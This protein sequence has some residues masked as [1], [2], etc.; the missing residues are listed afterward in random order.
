MGVTPGLFHH[1]MLHKSLAF[2]LKATGEGDG[3]ATF[4][5]YAAY[6]GNVD[7]SGDVLVK[8]AFADTLASFLEDGVLL[9]QHKRTDLIGR[10]LEAREDDKGLF[11]KGELCLAVAKARECYELMKAGILKKMSIGY[12]VTDYER[13][14]EHN[15]ETFAPGATPG[16]VARAMEWWGMA[17]K[18]VTLYEVSPVSI[19]ANPLADITA[20]KNVEGL[21]FDEHLLSTL[22]VV[23]GLKQRAAQ[24]ASIRQKD[25]RELS[26]K[27]REHLGELKSAIDAASGDI[28]A[29][30]TT[31]AEQKDDITPAIDGHELKE[32]LATR[33]A[34]LIAKGVL[35]AA[36]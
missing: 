16:D 6:F 3:V 19:P 2:H 27:H 14:G 1:S 21:R 26:E 24:I 10:P 28:A 8:G 29:L 17:L 30:L 7:R 13:L 5:G 12:D 9:A 35:S 34:A 36:V 11:L 32:R 18:R 22:A 23:K 31:N 20:V 33:R 4:E 15:I 25:G